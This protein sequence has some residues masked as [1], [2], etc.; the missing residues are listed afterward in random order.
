MNLRI[1]PGQPLRGEIDLPGDKSLSHRTALLAALAWGESRIENFLV[2]GVTRALL[3]CLS[4]LGVRWQ[5]DGSCLTV[6]GEG[7][8]ALR[9][10]RRAMDCGNSAT[11]LRML[12]GAVAA[13]GIPA[14]LDGS[15]GLRTRPMDRIVDPLRAMGVSIEA[16]PHGRAPVTLGAR[17]GEQ[18][19]RALSH[20]LPV[21]SAQVKTALL[22]AGLAADGPTRLTEPVRSRDHTERLLSSMGAEID[23]EP[24]AA[25]DPT[26]TVTLQP[27]SQPLR[28]LNLMLPGD[29]SSAAFLIVGALI[30]PGSEIRLREVGLNPS[31]TGLLDV[32]RGMGARI[33]V[34]PT[35][36]RHGEEIGNL[37]VRH[38]PLIG[39]EV[40]GPVIVRMI[41]EVP[42]FAVAAASAAGTTSVRG[43]GE[44]RVKESDRIA[45]L[46]GGLRALSMEIHERVSGFDIG[47]GGPPRGGSVG[48]AGDHRL[49]MAL[50]IAGLAAEAPVTVQGSEVIDE[51]FPDF[52]SALESLGA[53]I[54]AEAGE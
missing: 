47:G 22:L 40:K 23:V 49:A 9:P 37:T 33:E 17:P 14:V 52:V 25:G 5:L 30:T 44:L 27:P 16:G 45:G 34:E 54:R 39:A 42:A 12:A 50:A 10:P 46:C 6:T 3:T 8:Q 19:L 28:P 48:C 24:C 21:P 20:N 18:P 32:L 38:S 2:A 51:S 41:D 29:F 13:A 15:A 11:T 31:R 53:V 7:M 26:Y 43:A 36:T 35:G 4:E 1:I